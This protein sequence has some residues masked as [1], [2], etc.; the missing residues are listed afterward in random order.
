MMSLA[1]L[2]LAAAQPQPQPQAPRPGHY[3][4]Q[5]V[6]PNFDGASNSLS[7]MK[8]FMADGPILSVYVEAPSVVRRGPGGM[9]SV[10]LR[11]PETH[12]FSWAG[13]RIEIDGAAFPSPYADK[14]STRTRP[15][16]VARRF[17]VDRGNA[18]R[19]VLNRESGAWEIFATVF[20]PHLVSEPVN[21][22]A[23]LTL[24][25]PLD[26]LLAWGAGQ[27]SLT[28]YETMISAPR[29]PGRGLFHFGRERVTGSY[30]IDVA[31]LTRLVAQVR[32]ATERWEAG[33]PA[34]RSG[35]SLE[36]DE[37]LTSLPD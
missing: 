4:C 31:A 21:P 3:L 35:C 2:L 25:M 7:L 6:L 8:F 23:S 27:S 37:S 30:E 5:V 11:W 17:L 28:V 12:P 9:T 26:S 18:L 36:P 20:D 14:S 32:A 13:G 1:A 10:K 22:A 19:P 24:R 16:D 33:L 34:D 29:L 15:D